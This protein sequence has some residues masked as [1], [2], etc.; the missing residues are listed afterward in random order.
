MF[1]VHEH[2]EAPGLAGSALDGAAPRKCCSLFLV[3]NLSPL[4]TGDNYALLSSHCQA[5]FA[6]Q[7]NYRTFQEG[8]CVW[9][10]VCIFWG[11]QATRGNEEQRKEVKDNNNKAAKQTERC[12]HTIC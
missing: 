5:Q 3:C 10:C 12:S 2:V 6:T 4:L 7:I 11:M 1:L 9:V 8:V